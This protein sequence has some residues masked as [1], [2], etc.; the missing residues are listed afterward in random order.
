MGERVKEGEGT[1]VGRERTHPQVAT[2]Y[3]Q[4]VRP[5][6]GGVVPAREKISVSE[7]RLARDEKTCRPERSA[8]FPRTWDESC[9]VRSGTALSQT[10]SC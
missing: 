4:H 10:N 3:E 9:I 2:D 7:L 6:P 8:S 5:P 1:T